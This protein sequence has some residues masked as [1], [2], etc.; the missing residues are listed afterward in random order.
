MFSFPGIIVL[1][2]LIFV[3]PQEVFEVLKTLPFF[4]IFFGLSVFGLI[5][6]LRLRIIRPQPAPQ[7]IW[8]IL[9]FA[10]CLLTVALK[11]QEVVALVLDLAILFVWYYLLSHGIQTF[12][13]L[14]AMAVV[15]LVL[16]VFLSLVGVHQRTTDFECHKIEEG[17][18]LTIASGEPD[19]RA[20]VEREDCLINNPEPG[21]DYICERPGLLKTSTIGGR[22]RYRG[23][24]Q[25]PNELSL[26]LTVSLP[27]ML[28]F[29]RLRRT[30]LRLAG[31]A[32][33]LLV[34]TL[35]IWFSQSRGGQ[36][37]Y[38]AVI[39]VYFVRKYGYKGILIG[40]LACL[41]VFL[42][43]VSGAGREDASES[44]IERLECWW[45]GMTMFRY[46]PFMGVGYDQ[47]TE[48]HYLT[49]HNSYILAPAELGVPGTFFWL[50]TLYMSAK[51]PWVAVW[52]YKTGTPNGDLAHHWGM[53]ILASMV[54]ML[55]GAFFLSFC[56]H[57]MLWAYIALSGAYY[58][59]VRHHDSEFKVKFGIADFFLLVLGTVGIIAGMYLMTRVL[60]PP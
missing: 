59:A 35:C 31:L 36:I 44:S 20:C 33:I 41:P 13:T 17:V 2:L 37:V 43:V 14:S 3:R 15:L 12:R 38:L 50:G 52:R 46:N 25:D 7:L 9:F 18:M 32:G 48:H 47:F 4:Y 58:Q 39:G 51:I 60:P 10:W 24:L 56:Y 8:A 55:V 29:F 22:V 27:F 28:A 42:Y 49:A 5:V 1:V 19:G 30:W 57:Y 34:A 53:A 40:G 23:V 26:T 21:A 54:G 6:D 45:E 16:T 11:A